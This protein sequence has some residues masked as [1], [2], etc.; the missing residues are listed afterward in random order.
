MDVTQHIVQAPLD[1]PGLDTI[2]KAH[3]CDRAFQL[4]RASLGP[5]C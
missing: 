1:C 3:R 2:L 4:G 5:G